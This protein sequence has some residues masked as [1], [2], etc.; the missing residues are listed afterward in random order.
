M[1]DRDTQ[2]VE[3]ATSDALMVPD[4]SANLDLSDRASNP[5]KANKIARA[6]AKRLNSANPKVV[7]LAVTLLDTLVKNAQG[8]EV[9]AALAVN[10][11][12][13]ALREVCAGKCGPECQVRGPLQLPAEGI[14]LM[15]SYK[16]YAPR[17]LSWLRLAIS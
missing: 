4:W 16:I 9:Q 15:P 1:T 11:V 6:V 2:L 12:Q 5:D 3:A 7:Q 8:I 17:C 14:D 13:A 10:P